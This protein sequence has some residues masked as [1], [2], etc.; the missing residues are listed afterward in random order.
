MHIFS[1]QKCKYVTTCLLL[2]LE[3]KKKAARGAARWKREVAHGGLLKMLNEPAHQ[4]NA[5]LK[6]MYEFIGLNPGWLRIQALDFI[7]DV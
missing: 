4:V 3:T 2:V 1:S 6:L 5:F 7:V